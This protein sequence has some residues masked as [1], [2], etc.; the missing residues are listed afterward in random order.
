MWSC[1]IGLFTTGAQCDASRMAKP[2]KASL[3]GPNVS[4]VLRMVG[5]QGQA[6]FCDLDSPPLRPPSESPTHSEDL[7]Q[8]CK[9][10]DL[11]V[12]LGSCVQPSG[13]RLNGPQ[14]TMPS[15]KRAATEG[16][17]SGAAPDCGRRAYA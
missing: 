8:D 5:G 10:I 17:A 11:L 16:A 9:V 15:Q 12:L 14:P 6:P 1:N 7:P 2:M 3:A 4:R 13:E